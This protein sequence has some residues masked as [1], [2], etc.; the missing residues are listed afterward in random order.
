[1]ARMLPREVKLVS[2]WTGLP[3][4]EVWSA[5]SGPT[6]WILHYIKTYIYLVTTRRQG[7]ITTVCNWCFIDSTLNTNC[8][9]IHHWRRQ[10]LYEQRPQFG[11]V[12]SICKQWAFKPCIKYIA[13]RCS[14]L[15]TAPVT[16]ERLCHTTTIYATISSTIVTI[17][18]NVDI[19]TF[20]V[21]VAE[22]VRALALNG[23]RT[24]PAGFDSHCGRLWVRNF[25]NSVNPSLPVSF[26]WDTKSRWSLLCGVYARGSKRSHQSALECVTVVD[27]TSH[28]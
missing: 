10:R 28:P 24:L 21:A 27:S 6:D 19:L 5:L 11:I 12:Y 18:S 3:G 2:E 26:G 23:D 4:G 8:E 7:R 9:A 16:S 20:D 17:S 15:N 25:G 13:T 14:A 1:M 22:W